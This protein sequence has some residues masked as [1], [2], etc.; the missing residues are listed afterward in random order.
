[1]KWAVYNPQHSLLCWL[2][3]SD[4][5]PR[6]FQRTQHFCTNQKLREKSNVRKKSGRKRKSLFV[7][8]HKSNASI[9]HAMTISLTTTIWKIL[10]EKGDHLTPHLWP[11]P[12]F[13]LGALCNHN[14]YLHSSW[15]QMLKKVEGIT[16]SS[17]TRSHTA[18][19]IERIHYSD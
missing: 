9:L 18:P 3:Q 1:M 14:V 15:T 4:H 8:E 2:W 7:N 10:P 5:M 12:V 11:N 6:K 13:P 19:V 16:K 17:Q